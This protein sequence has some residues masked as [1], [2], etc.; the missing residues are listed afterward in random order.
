MII[1]GH[2]IHCLDLDMPLVSSYFSASENESV[3]FLLCAFV[4]R[5][6]VNI[7]GCDDNADTPS[8]FV[9]GK[10]GW[11]ITFLLVFGIR[12]DVLVWRAGYDLILSWGVRRFPRLLRV[13]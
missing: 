9:D 2:D 4:S 8:L 11:L 5:L 7:V 12:T 1:T 13:L 10:C 6:R 3:D